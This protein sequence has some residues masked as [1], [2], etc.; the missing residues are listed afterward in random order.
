MNYI[1]QLNEYG[2]KTRVPV[3]YEEVD[4]TGPDHIK[5]FTLRAVVGGRPYP[6]GVGKNKREAKE[7]AAQRALE[8]L[9]QKE[10]N[11]FT[12]PSTSQTSEIP[13]S[14][15]QPNYQ[16]WLN[17][18]IHK[19]RVTY[20]AVESTRVGSISA[21]HCCK[22]VS[23]DGKSY[24]EAYGRVK[25]EAKEEAAKLVYK[26]ILREQGVIED[27][28]NGHA[29]R[30]TEE[31]SRNVS[32]PSNSM[33]HERATPT[34]DLSSDVP[35]NFIGEL[36]HYCQQQKL[37]HDFK[38]VKRRGPSHSPEFVYKVVINN[39]EYPEG[40]G[41]TAKEAKQQ[42]AQ[43]A[44]N[45][46]QDPS[47]SDSLELCKLSLSEDDSP[48]QTPETFESQDI[49][50][51]RS[52][53]TS[54]SNSIVFKDSSKEI[55]KVE[56][57]P[58]GP[59]Q[60]KPKRILAPNF[61][62]SPNKKDALN[63]PNNSANQGTLSRFEQD[64]DLIERIGKGGFGRVFKARNICDETYYA[65]KIVKFTEKAKREVRALARL[66]HPHI[67]R[68]HHC[69]IDIIAYRLEGSDSSS[70]SASGSNSTLK[71]LYIKMELCEGNTLAM[72]IEERNARQDPD[73]RQTAL[74]I[75]KQ[76]VNAV[77][78]IHS[79]DLIHRDLKPANIMFGG[80]HEVKI[81]DFGLVT[82]A[83]ND[84][85]ETM[86]ERTERTGTKSYMSPEQNQ[87][88]YDRKVDIF[89]LGLIYFELVWTMFTKAQK[90]NIWNEVREQNFPEE[91][92]DQFC[93]EHKLI[94]R[95][96]CFNPVERPDAQD[97][98]PELENVTSI[99]DQNI[100]ERNKTV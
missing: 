24:P 8:I 55:S 5:T 68:Y 66:H 9:Q 18:H 98:V 97:L 77:V 78:Y 21:P 100:N 27:I 87:S 58:P 35:Q 1:A 63:L 39:H 34:R 6:E 32:P 57:P 84:N 71:H 70:T 85:D 30:Q 52:N 61:N 37:T 91:F 19:T 93:F 86:L 12:T 65:V 46:I 53:A 88:K 60:N 36:N 45:A 28:S 29:S 80:D 44:W 95:M 42:A 74:G 69:W 54:E 59:A 94:R 25:K 11:G 62:N 82:D 48:S 51:L 75:T 13:T 79:Q 4:V 81:G 43:L 33:E 99:Q 2:Q 20:T 72:W 16:C 10:S 38:L 23:G 67:V 96:L 7:N 64:F 92:S 76:I 41:K 47:Q 17:E 22:Y 56:V 14:I 73:R 31:S 49:S 50:A 40:R 83:D 26:E 89:A 15:T 90:Y 3:Q